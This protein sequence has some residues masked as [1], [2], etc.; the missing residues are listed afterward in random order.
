MKG[1]KILFE[2]LFCFLFVNIQASHCPGE[3]EVV[4]GCTR[5]GRLALGLRSRPFACS[6]ASWFFGRGL[7]HCVFCRKAL[8]AGWW[9]TNEVAFSGAAKLRLSRGRLELGTL[10]GGRLARRPGPPAGPGAAVSRW[11]HAF[12]SLAVGHGP[13]VV[14]G[15]GGLA[16]F[17][18]PAFLHGLSALPVAPGAAGHRCGAV[19]PVPE[20]GTTHPQKNPSARGG[21]PDQKGKSR[22]PSSEIPRS[23]H[24][25]WARTPLCRLR[26][27]EKWSLPPTGCVTFGRLLNMSGPQFLHL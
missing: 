17:L 1:S 16:G 13:P 26:S 3:S 7:R 10:A 22:L 21:G 5:F 18:L 23:R 20:G 14:V 12:A 25:A 27:E 11:N 2:G 19:L 4:S 15:S 8:T 24:Q 9:M 6:L